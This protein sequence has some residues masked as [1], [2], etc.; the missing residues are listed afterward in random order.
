MTGRSLHQNER[1]LWSTQ[2]V[3]G[4][5]GGEKAVIHPSQN[6]PEKRFGGRGSFQKVKRTQEGDLPRKKLEG[7]E[8]IELG[9]KG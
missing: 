8:V 1:A 6:S 9:G 4:G 2:E 5:V 3:R 7:G